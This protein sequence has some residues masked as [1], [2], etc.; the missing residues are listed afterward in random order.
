MRA[1]VYILATLFGGA[2]F[3]D[4]GSAI[5][6]DEAPYGADERGVAMSRCVHQFE[7]MADG[8]ERA[9]RLCGCA[10]DEFESR[11]M[12]ADDLFDAKYYNEMSHITQGCAQVEGIPYGA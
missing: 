9:E 12:A 4:F 5:R 3:Y 1:L 11:G 8:T 6:D 7:K 2:Y 10:L